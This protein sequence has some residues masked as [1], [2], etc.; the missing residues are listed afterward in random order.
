MRRAYIIGADGY[1]GSAAADAMREAGKEVVAMGRGVA[2]DLYFD[3]SSFDS[4]SLDS[5][6]PGSFL[7][8]AA[9]ISSPDVCERDYDSAYRVNVTGTRALVSHAVDQGCDVVFLSSDAVFS[10]EPGV[11][12]DEDS[13]MDPQF[14]YGKMKAEVEGDFSGDGH[15]KALRLSYVYSDHD[16]AMRYMLG[17]AGRGIK[18]EIFHPY[19]RSYIP[20]SDVVKTVLFLEENWSALPDWRLNLAGT[21]LVSRIRV[22]DELKQLLAGFDYSV[23]EPPESFYDVRPRVTQMQSKYLYRFGICRDE[24][25]TKKLQ[26]EM[27]GI[28]TYD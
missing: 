19:Y 27:K 25:F 17:C 11:I 24:C 23:V 4:D 12:Y 8:V 13:P 28:I 2:A 9:A 22:A 5:I 16:K 3:L 20:L 18:A 26:Q 7:L 1:I 14:A 6:E 15:F 10:S 21:E